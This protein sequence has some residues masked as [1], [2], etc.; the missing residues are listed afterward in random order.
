MSTHW[1]KIV[2]GACKPKHVPP[3]AKYID[4]LVQST[5][6]ADGS[7]QD[8]S[9]ALRLKL[10]D[11]N[12]TVVFKA[13]FVIHTL[14][15]VG[16]AQEVM[17]YW[18][19]LH[20]RDN[21][22]LGLKDVV[23]M[24]D[25]PQNLSR[26]ANYL[27]VRFKCFAALKHDPIR[28]RSEAPASLR[29]SSRNGANRLRTLTVE[30][31]LLREVGTLQ[32]LLDALIDCKFYLED[33][34]DDLVMSALRILVKDLL[35][36]FQAVNEGVINVLEHYFEM[37]HVDATTA[38]KTYKIFCKQCERVVAYLGVA[39]KLQNVINVNIPNLRH[40]PVSL[41][42]S[43]EEYLNDP[44]F[45]ANRQEYKESKRVADGKSSAASNNSKP[46][47]NPT[48]KTP[49]TNPPSSSSKPNDG[50]KAFIDFFESIESEQQ[51]MFNPVS[52]SPT[53]NYFQQ[54]ASLQPF[55][56]SQTIGMPAASSVFTQPTSMTNTTSLGTASMGQ[57][58]F[59]NLNASQ[60]SSL[61]HSQPI[62]LTANQ[63]LL[64]PQL[65]GFAVGGQFP[66]LIPPQITG[67]VNPF[68]Q[69]MFSTQQ[70]PL[71]PQATGYNPFSQF[72][73]NPSFNLAV[74]SESI[75][76]SPWSNQAFQI[77]RSAGAMSAPPVG[78][79]PQTETSSPV[80]FPLTSQSFDPSSSALKAQVTGSRNPFASLSGSVTTPPVPKLPSTN[81][82]SMNALAASA[83]SQSMAQQRLREQAAQLQFEQQQ[84]KQQAQEALDSQILNKNAQEEEEA[85]K[86]KQ[87]QEFFN[88]QLSKLEGEGKNV[89]KAK[90]TG[91]NGLFANVAS[92]FAVTKPKVEGQSHT[93]SSE[94]AWPSGMGNGLV[95]QPTG[96]IPIKT[97][98]Y[99]SSPFGQLNPSLTAPLS[100]QPTGFGG[101][102]V[103]KFQPTSAF[104][105]SLAAQVQEKGG[106]QFGGGESLLLSTPQNNLKQDLLSMNELSNSLTGIPSISNGLNQLSTGDSK[107]NQSEP[108][109]SPMNNE[110]SNLMM[111]SNDLSSLPLHQ[112]PQSQTTSNSNFPMLTSSLI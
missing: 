101:S 66:N 6:Q 82:L 84:Q 5:N 89:E 56:L 19:G 64:Q 105:A 27:L 50:Q 70:T 51:S 20:S 74:N 10:R 62:G 71:I 4:A 54:Q 78:P 32:K 33:I 12:S 58:L 76:P 61:H 9:L 48:L 91:T 108:S 88:S 85:R 44:N 79:P 80:T 77:D 38:L 95:G 98:S 97:G 104:G 111:F 100:S 3:K 93:G 7:F 72:V 41:A 94:T 11:S 102:S 40:A 15:R 109:I 87:F 49:V 92:E 28:T 16:N 63:Q 26:Y 29:N 112:Q 59:G 110:Q 42:G 69:T 13:L 35:I 25:T 73:S 68:R 96:I 45:E 47:S 60:P 39:K 67:T 81:T 21:R 17:S 23:T 24:T 2:A 83:F 65:T 37:S 53:S 34:D 14:V 22:A 52:M 106:N 103:K 99:H 8:V 107:L 46:T 86:K 30:K 36:L 18:S 55:A 1:S 31:G 75:P 90:L 57:A 43:L